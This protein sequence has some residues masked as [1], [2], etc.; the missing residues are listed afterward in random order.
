M[1]SWWSFEHIES[2]QPAL[3]DAIAA[4]PLPPVSDG[5]R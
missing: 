3:W 2:E 5:R 4:V 1:L